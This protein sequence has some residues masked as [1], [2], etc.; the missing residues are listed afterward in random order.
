MFKLIKIQ[1][2]GRH[3]PELEKLR[4]LS[5][6]KIKAGEAIILDD[7]DIAS[8]PATVKPSHIAFAD[9]D[10]ESKYVV[11]YPISSDMVFETTVNASPASLL[12]GYKVTIGKD[13]DGNSVCVTSTTEAGIVTIVSLDNAEKIGDKITVRF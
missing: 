13:S 2:S 5:A 12:V 1:N 7:G 8:C 9:A 3:V 10:E 6:I 11:C 4:K